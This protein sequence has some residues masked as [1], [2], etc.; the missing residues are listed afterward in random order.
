M[1]SF[2]SHLTYYLWLLNYEFITHVTFKNNATTSGNIK[3]LGKN[4]TVNIMLYNDKS[5]NKTAM[6][7]HV[8]NP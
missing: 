3:C 2:W 4:K 5:A 8:S 1:F 6:K 7:I